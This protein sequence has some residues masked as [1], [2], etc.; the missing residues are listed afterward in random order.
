MVSRDHRKFSGGGQAL[1]RQ[2]GQAAAIFSHSYFR[3]CKMNRRF[4]QGVVSGGQFVLS[5][6]EHTARHLHITVEC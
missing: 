3:Q 1:P 6:L 2:R 5:N 4:Q